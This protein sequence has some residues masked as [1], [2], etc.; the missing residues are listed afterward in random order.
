[1]IP[2]PI[3][4]FT[5]KWLQNLGQLIFFSIKFEL[6]LSNAVGHPGSS[7]IEYY[8]LFNITRSYAALRAADLDWIVGPGYSLGWVHSGEKP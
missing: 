6:A 8:L 7:N 2:M 5:K 1:M 4:K 3:M